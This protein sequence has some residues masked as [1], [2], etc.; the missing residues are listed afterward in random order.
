MN[1]RLNRFK[2]SR[3]F[4]DLNV[5]MNRLVGI[6]W[7]LA[8]NSYDYGQNHWFPLTID[9]NGQRSGEISP[10]QIFMIFKNW[11]NRNDSEWVWRI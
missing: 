6:I 4:E 5:G 9:S 8:F 11:M 10:N 1:L 2:L 3:I 7:R